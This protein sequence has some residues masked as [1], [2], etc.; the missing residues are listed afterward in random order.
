MSNFSPMCFPNKNEKLYPVENGVYEYRTNLS[1]MGR[2][3]LKAD[4]AGKIPYAYRI[5]KIQG[6]GKNCI[7]L[8]LI[9]QKCEEKVC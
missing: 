5:T 1:P 8:N 4:K 7:F 9:V 2:M 3:Y 6:S